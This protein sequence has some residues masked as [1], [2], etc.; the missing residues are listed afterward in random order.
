MST[1]AVW[2]R[3]ADVVDALDLS[4][5]V[6]AVAAGFAAEAAGR[7]VTMV[8]THLAWPGGQ[9]HAV[10][11]MLDDVVGTKTW[12]HTAGGAQPLLVLFGR[13]DGRV[14]AVI[15]AFALGQ[16]RTAAVSAVLTDCLARTDA[17]TMAM[18][19]T[20]KQALAQVAAVAA[21]RPLRR[22][23]VWSPNEDRRAAF[24]SRVETELD[25]AAVACGSPADVCAEA[26]V[27]T[28]ATRASA[29]FL[30][31]ADVER[32]VHL[33]AVGA[34]TPERAELEPALVE[35]CVVVADNVA[36]ARE[37]S[38]E[39]GD[40]YG[41]DD[42]AWARVRSLAD[43]VAAGAGRP[44]DADVTLGKAM[45]VGLADVAIGVACLHAALAL[46]RGTP[47]GERERVG[48]RLKVADRT[49]RQP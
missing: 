23:Q 7:A 36:Q 18:C 29:P 16:M 11:G 6:D 3:E 30:A 35:R 46:G 19:G 27:V 48:P 15:E 34:I 33:N 2:L 49:R 38:A 9:L 41:D 43:V 5:A 12:A 31:S 24:A 13:D 28:V 47:L 10:G 39:L 4:G 42:A 40:A 1:P 20:G 17:D 25:L 44:A 26:D 22:V 21:V 45:G 37:L 14:V 32:G 8:K